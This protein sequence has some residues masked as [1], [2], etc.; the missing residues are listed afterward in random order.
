VFKPFQSTG[1]GSL[2][3]TEAQEAVELVLGAF[4]IP[5][6][7]QLPRASFREQ[8]IAQFTE[9]MPMVRIDEASR[10]L[11]VDRSASEELERFYETWSPSSKL[12]IS[13]PY[14]RGLHAFLRL[15]R[16]RRFQA[17]KGHVTG[18]LTFTLGLADQQGRAVYF[19]EELR[20]IALMVLKGKARWQVELL[21]E[22][23][24][25]VL[26]FLDEP[27]VS[28][29]GSSAYMGV[30]ASEALRLLREAVSDAQAQGA[31]V[32]I[33]CCGRADW[34]MLLQSGLDVLSF[35]AYEF[36][37]TLSLYPQEL[38]AFLQRGGFLAW[39]L[40]PTTEAIRQETEESLKRRF[41][42]LMEHL[43]A[44]VPEG[45][46]RERL[47][48]TPSCGAGSRSKEEAVKVLQLLMRLKEALA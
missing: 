28:A 15:T 6:W 35:D 34:G 45:L 3:H 17:L 32:G 16:G 38:K 14:A 27:I 43:C 20:E 37:R 30:G 11:W 1:I 18:P 40:V 23:A 25:E 46:L 26:I 2:P 7:P 39:G 19:D 8:M 24:G 44:Y 12:A 5:F 42:E 10:R 9:G 29:L 21:R 36:G 31:L 22:R 47:L 41:Q 4:D 13:E 33:H 48:L